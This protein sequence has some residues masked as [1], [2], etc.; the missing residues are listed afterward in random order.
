VVGIRFSMVVAGREER[1]VPKH[2]LAQVVA[3]PLDDIDAV[4]NQRARAVRRV[5]SVAT[6][7]TDFLTLLEA[8]GL[9]PE[10]G[11]KG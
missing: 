1:A 6:D 4:R 7:V 11:R 2:D 5:A 10:E 9:T 3:A 8:L